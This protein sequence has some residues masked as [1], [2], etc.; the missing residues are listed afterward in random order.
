VSFAEAPDWHT[1][2]MMDSGDREHGDADQA[3]VADAPAEPPP[4]TAK[5]NARLKRKL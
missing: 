2:Q 5:L 1:R 3:V 4:S